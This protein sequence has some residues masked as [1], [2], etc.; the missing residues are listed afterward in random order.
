MGGSGRKLPEGARRGPLPLAPPQLER[1]ER[2][3]LSVES[4]RS[5]HEDGS[6][7]SAAFKDLC[8][9]TFVHRFCTLVTSFGRIWG[10]MR[11]RQFG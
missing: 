3:V 5:S 1:V 8:K 9:N 6:S 2:G 7:R 4:D 10:K 11:S